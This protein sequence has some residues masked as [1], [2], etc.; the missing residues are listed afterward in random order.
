LSS[1]SY[2]KVPAWDRSY[3]PLLIYTKKYPLCT[4]D[5]SSYF[6]MIDWGMAEIWMRIYSQRD[7]G[8]PRWKSFRLKMERRA[9]GFKTTILNRSLGVV[10]PDVGVITRPG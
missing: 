2:L 3:I 4:Y 6:S 1:C 7:V 8:V 9:F 10:I 5:R